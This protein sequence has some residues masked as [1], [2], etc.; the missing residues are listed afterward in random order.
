MYSAATLEQD[1]QT[2]RQR[3]SEHVLDRA[4]HLYVHFWC[5]HLDGKI[6]CAVL[7]LVGV[8]GVGYLDINRRFLLFPALGQGGRR[9]ATRLLGQFERIRGRITTKEGV[10]CFNIVCFIPHAIITF[11]ISL[12]DHFIGRIVKP[13]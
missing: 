4:G 13:E 10:S 5:H 2:R 11:N 12:Q 6:S 7:P 1:Y 3:L 9:A 8:C